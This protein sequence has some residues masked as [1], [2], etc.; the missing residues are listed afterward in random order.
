M[1]GVAGSGGQ[2]G[3]G[4]S[5]TAGTGGMA[6]QAGTA[7]GG[8]GAAS[9]GGGSDTGGQ[10]MVVTD[11][12]S[13]SAVNLVPL[14]GSVMLGSGHLHLS[15]TTRLVTEARGRPVAE[16]LAQVLRRSTGL[17]LEIVEG[18]AR[19]SDIELSLTG[20]AATLEQEGYQLEVG[21]D[22]VSVRAA[23][24]PGLFYAT[25][26]LRQLL[27]PRVEATTLQSGVPWRLPRVSIQDAPRFSWRGMSFDV[28]RH[29]FGKD[30]VKRLIELAAYHKLNRFHLH[31]SDDQGWRIQIDSWPKLTQIGGSTQVG[32]GPGGFYTK[33]DYAEIVSYAQARFVTVVPEIDMPGHTLAALASYA[34]LNQSGTAPALYTG[35]KVGI[36]TLMVGADVTKRFVQDVLGELAAMTPGPYLHIGGDEAP[37]TPEADYRA[38]VEETQKVVAAQGKRLV[39]W[40]EV[41]NTSLGAGSISQHWFPECPSVAAAAR[42]MDIILS[43][44]TNAYLDMKYDA[45]I[46]IGHDWAGLV[47]VQKA[48][49]WQPTL[50][51]V[52]TERILGVEA[53]LWTE[54][55]TSRADI[56]LLVFPRLCGHAEIA[57]S[58]APLTFAD[59]AQRLRQHGERLKALGVGFYRAPEV[60]WNE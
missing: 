45:S 38:F 40:C 1:N 5:S 48:Y 6:T 49:E 3:G 15:T 36:S 23:D 58:R 18:A 26:T 54:F 35:T 20:D 42:G 17:S 41:G 52:P 2:G 13:V 50:A 7:S 56:D 22:R 55:V 11:D 8:G 4:A 34:E 46:P 10:P 27:D 59:Y 25:I 43:P 37:M 32:G 30:E 47:S 28:A 53:A 33:A 39:G 57:W 12:D 9:G 31:L 19:G 60:D 51:G 29:F 21:A 24:L 44:A 14:P 16:L